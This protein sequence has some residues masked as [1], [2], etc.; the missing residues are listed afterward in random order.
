MKYY[1]CISVASK[2]KSMFGQLSNVKS[3]FYPIDPIPSVHS[4]QL[5][6]DDN[7][8]ESNFLRNIIIFGIFKFFEYR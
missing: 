4:D 1:L 2:F 3:N 8:C 7:Q 6:V 5:I